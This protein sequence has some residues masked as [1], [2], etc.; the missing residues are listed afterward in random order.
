MF[1]VDDISQSVV[2]EELTINNDFIPSCL[3]TARALIKNPKILILDE[4]TSGKFQ[5]QI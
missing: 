3:Y 5:D 4:A 2:I 1:H